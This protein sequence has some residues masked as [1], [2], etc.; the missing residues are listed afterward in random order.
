MEITATIIIIIIIPLPLSYN[1]KMLSQAS[2]ANV[3]GPYLHLKK[4]VKVILQVIG[5]PGN[6]KELIKLSKYREYL[7]LE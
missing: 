6:I 7:W 4:D 5:L 2:N 1:Y 3:K